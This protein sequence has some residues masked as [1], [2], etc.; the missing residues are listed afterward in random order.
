MKNGMGWLSDPI[1]HM[2]V[3]G[4]IVAVWA[5]SVGAGS[6][7]SESGSRPAWCQKCF[8]R[9]ATSAPCP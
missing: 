2:V 6:S 1:F 7:N 3:V 9:H 5:I 8:A 4:L